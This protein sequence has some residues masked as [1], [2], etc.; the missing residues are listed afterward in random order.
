M[1]EM[2]TKDY[3]RMKQLDSLTKNRKRKNPGD[4][5]RE[6]ASKRTREKLKNIAKWKSKSPKSMQEKFKEWREKRHDRKIDP[7]YLLNKIVP[8]GGIAGGAK[9]LKDLIKKSGA[10]YSGSGDYKE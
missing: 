6:S 4:V 3:Q 2:S 5:Q 10:G 7:R 1:A 8:A 9:T